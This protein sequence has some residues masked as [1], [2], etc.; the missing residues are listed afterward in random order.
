[1][2]ASLSDL[3]SNPSTT[4]FA[5]CRRLYNR[6]Q[7]IIFSD[8]LL[9]SSAE[10][11]NTR[12]KLK[13]QRVKPSLVGMG[14]AI[15]AIAQPRLAAFQGQ[16]AIEEGRKQ[17]A[18]SDYAQQDLFDPS[19]SDS[20]GSDGE[21]KGSSSKKTKS[22][23][24]MPSM[25]KSNAALQGL[26]AQFSRATTSSANADL[27][28]SSLRGSSPSYLP[29]APLP[30]ADMSSTSAGILT[31]THTRSKPDFLLHKA[32]IRRTSSA[33]PSPS[34]LDVASARPS[35]SH[36][37]VNLP[38]PS[39]SS[40]SPYSRPRN[41]QNAHKLDD[42]ARSSGSVLKP[43]ILDNSATR[44][45]DYTNS[46]H[47]SKARQIRNSTTPLASPRLAAS[48]PSLHPYSSS[49]SSLSQT[50]LG[51]E[52]SLPPETISLLLRSYA[53]RSQLD[54]ITSLQ[55]IATRLIVVPRLARLS[56]L[57][58]EL[59][60]LNHGLP[61]GCCLC[62]G[63]AGQGTGSLVSTDNGPSEN[64]ISSIAASLSSFFTR[65]DPSKARRAHHRIVRISPSESV[66][67]NSADRAPFLIHVEILE[68]DLDF[69]PNRRQ[70]AE[71][72][73]S[74]MAER[75]GKISKARNSSIEPVD[76]TT[77]QTD[78]PQYQER[79]KHHFPDMHNFED[80]T[81][82][83][84]DETFDKL[85][86]VSEVSAVDSPQLPENQDAGNK[87]H[88]VPEEVDL[89]E[90]MYG[91]FSVHDAAA[92]PVGEYH[93]NIHNRS[94][95]EKAWRR[96]ESRKSFHARTI[97]GADGNASSSTTQ[98]GTEAS[99][100]RSP[101]RREPLSIDEYAERMRMAAIMLAQLNASQ[102]VPLTGTDAVTG[103]VGAGV[104]M[105]VNL[106]YGVGSVVGSVVGVGVDAVRAS[107]GSKRR[108]SITATSL[109]SDSAGQGSAGLSAPVDDSTA[110]AGLSNVSG[111][112]N[113]ASFPE[114]IRSP[115]TLS[116]ANLKNSAS[117]SPTIPASRS[118]RQR[119]LSAQE[120]SAI[121]E[122]IMSEMMSLEDE[123]MSRMKGVNRSERV[124][125]MAS[126]APGE[127]VEEESI[128]MRAINKDDPSG[129]V[130]SESWLDKKSRIRKG[131]PYGHLLSWD[132]FSV[133]VKTGADLRQ[134]QLAVQLIKEF[135]RIWTETSCPH[136]VR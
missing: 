78:A 89:V 122:R 121:R 64:R 132:V 31:S 119:V 41:S 100:V 99:P 59:T 82:A 127:T 75:E 63:C 40:R 28:S 24:T 102:Q 52:L 5:T 90:Q 116:Q 83:A 94:V 48:T 136:W 47:S 20:E 42:R 95:D 91:S 67:L 104:G 54:L 1:M 57:R 34:Y 60:V 27:P 97:S 133:I 6:A 80:S 17:Q 117:T 101:R 4:S 22:S 85:E 93:P 108:T 72:I 36:S 32:A 106:T 62:L 37:M 118:I 19:L 68:G 128:V 81:D 114:G 115:Q 66:V 76:P 105:G 111:T 38:T 61:R 15:A 45:I 13:S 18:S 125:M 35:H 130:L 120:A 77:T 131:S 53:C 43:L 103:A 55:D 73:R 98:N 88:L 3:S 74:V 51:A 29:G 50:R 2:Q 11:C 129:S 79:S 84:N 65:S 33:V 9:E 49:A 21:A 7:H 10:A 71:D 14:I 92:L 112:I 70:N 126:G 8:A 87:E 30:L 44:T 56:A 109:A 12:R 123:R 86:G 39:T 96:A 69:D 134:E 23:T 113:P 25:S 16:I 135:G 58:A 46:V 107:L 110:I 26:K 124:P